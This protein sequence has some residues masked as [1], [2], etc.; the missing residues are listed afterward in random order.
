MKSAWI[1]A[2]LNV[3]RSALNPLTVKVMIRALKA[4]PVSPLGSA[5]L[6]RITK[7]A[8]SMPSADLERSVVKTDSAVRAAPIASV[9]T[10]KHVMLAAVKRYPAP[11]PMSL[12]TTRV[13]THPDN[14]SEEIAGTPYPL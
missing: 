10:R 12:N 8:N 11:V 2:P 14:L 4:S 1:D 13:C 6:S 7:R 5:L 9:A 3:T